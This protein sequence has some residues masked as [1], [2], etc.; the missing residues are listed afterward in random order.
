MSPDTRERILLKQI[1]N[2]EANQAP[3]WYQGPNGE[4]IAGTGGHYSHVTAPR[5]TAA[6]DPAGHGKVA[7]TD[8]QGHTTWVT[9]NEAVNITRQNE[10]ASA[11]TN[12]LKSVTEPYQTQFY[13]KD[14]KPIEK[15]TD[16][17]GRMST[18]QA[19]ANPEDAV[20]V[21]PD[22]TVMPMKEFQKFQTG[23]V[24]KGEGKPPLYRVADQQ[25]PAARN[26]FGSGQQS[27]AQ[28]RAMAEQALKANKDPQ[29]VAALYKQMTGED[30]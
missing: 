9:A 12:K 26:A 24:K 21:L 11:Q 30:F 13:S 16:E 29:A 18:E 15:V 8:N 27:H 5:P 28:A 19:L 23:I 3:Q 1:A 20:A 6:E 22:K 17:T 25:A 10:E 4:W 2:R 14:F 7:V